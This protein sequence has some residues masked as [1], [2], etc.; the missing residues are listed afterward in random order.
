MTRIRV[1]GIFGKSDWLLSIYFFETMANFISILVVSIKL[2]VNFD[3]ENYNKKQFRY[4][5]I[6]RYIENQFAKKDV[7]VFIIQ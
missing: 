3:D 4:V 7:S 2:S 1:F 6:K 5:D